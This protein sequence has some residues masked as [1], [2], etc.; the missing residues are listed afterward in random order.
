MSR[1][2]PSAYETV[3]QKAVELNSP[4]VPNVILC[5][6]DKA[7]RFPSLRTVA[8]RTFIT[9]PLS[10]RPYR[11]E[12]PGP[13]QDLLTHNQP[14]YLE[15]PVISNRKA[16]SKSTSRPIRI[17]LSDTTL[18]VVPDTLVDQWRSEITKHVQ[19]FALDV[20]FL[21]SK[22]TSTDEDFA[23]QRLLDCDLVLMSHSRFAAEE[24][25]GRLDMTLGVPR[26]CSCP[27]IGRTRSRNCKCKSASFQKRLSPLMQIRWKR[28]IVD[29]GHSMSNTSRITNLAGLL[30]VDARWVV[31]GTPT[32]H[33]TGE[34]I[35]MRH[36]DSRID[37]QMQSKDVSEYFN[38]LES[39]NEPEPDEPAV[40]S[41]NAD[42]EDLLRLGH[43]FMQ[44]LQIQPF[45][46]QRAAWRRDIVS[47][48]CDG[49]PEGLRR[50]EAV[51]HR[52]LI[53]NRV[54][55]L[56]KDVILP[57]ISSRIVRLPFERLGWISYNALLAQI[58]L[59]VVTSESEHQDYIFHPSNRKHL[60]TVIDNLRHSCFH[61]T[62]MPLRDVQ[63][64]YDFCT[65]SIERERI[66][67]KGWS[68]DILQKCST[69]LK[70]AL[71]NKI[72]QTLA[73]AHELPYY[74]DELPTAL[75][76]F[77][78]DVASTD[79]PLVYPIMYAKSILNLRRA[80]TAP[81]KKPYHEGS[82]QSL[83]E[84]GLAYRLLQERE[85]SRSSCQKTK[86]AAL[87]VGT[88]QSILKQQAQS[89]EVYPAD[90]P[91]YG[92][93]R[94][95]SVENLITPPASPASVNKQHTI[96]HQSEDSFSPVI[97]STCP[98]DCFPSPEDLNDNA[99]L[100]LVHRRIRATGSSKLNYLIDQLLVHAPQEKCLVFCQHANTQY[101]L[102]EALDVVGIKY[103]IY[104]SAGLNN[105]RRSQYIVT[106]NTSERIRVMIMDIKL[107]GR[108]LN[109]SSASRVY[110][111]EPVW[112]PDL[113]A[114]AIK[115][116]H[117]I[118]QTRPVTVETLVIAGSIEDEILE[119]RSHM[120]QEDFASTKT[121]TDDGK[122]RRLLSSCR[123][124]AWRPCDITLASTVPL[125]AEVD[126]VDDPD[127]DLVPVAAAIPASRST[128][129][130]TTSERY[131]N[132][133]R[134]RVRFA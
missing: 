32:S 131:V 33:L 89:L 101:Y 123:F 43:I 14:F 15:Y 61:W 55:D 81:D 42:M 67:H 104:T 30:H 62:G 2:P 119:R 122:M 65:A 79:Q 8:A 23:V 19:D 36:S 5:D 114:Q 120:S 107:A 78:I 75:E 102:A 24:A 53:R 41:N 111:V 45:S 129:V 66:E 121:L 57:E 76:E 72:W 128:H 91:L 69:H 115:R 77:W 47:P 3:L 40:T 16:R 51:L 26:E 37:T 49:H 9:T 28:L 6:L 34:G 31:S 13:L 99:S 12:M 87:P 44:F 105:T 110:F 82:E 92:T 85:R 1:P 88:P 17:Y 59:N 25:Y 126:A 22:K 71:D 125:I 7:S 10:T 27:Y 94:K 117:R 68:I 11:R 64:A 116:A 60:A 93:K 97:P 109:I 127:R 54:E 74:V 84:E 96:V 118:G 124:M 130:P 103:L 80:F 46:N 4:T 132:Q 56:E 100:Q 21:P 18:V 134:K 52:V 98:Q 73:T 58:A 39:S 63:Q 95:R 50:L 48:Y 20:L 108:G 70:V 133:E 112:Q 106:Y 86:F 29:E 35:R 83:I 113:E 90:K 38:S